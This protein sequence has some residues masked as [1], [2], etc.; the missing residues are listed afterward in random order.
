MMDPAQQLFGEL[1]SLLA[2]YTYTN[3]WIQELVELLHQMKRAYPELY[4]AQCLGYLK[5][6]RSRWHNPLL[7]LHTIAQLDSYTEVLPFPIWKL[8]APGLPS[9]FIHSPSLIHVNSLVLS[10]DWCRDAGFGSLQ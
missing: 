2:K 9:E 5:D 3:A 7:S 10:E 8:S 6:V 1:R 4:E